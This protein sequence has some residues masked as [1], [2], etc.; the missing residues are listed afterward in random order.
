MNNTDTMSPQELRALADKKEQE[1]KVQKIGYLKHNLYSLDIDYDLSR[2]L[3]EGLF[4]IEKS[5]KEEI[6]KKIKGLFKIT[7]KKNTKFVCFI[8]DDK[9]CWFDDENIGIESMPQEWAEKNLIFSNA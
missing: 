4:C 7:A 1:N 3:R 9:E 8:V 6:E 5:E 2:Y